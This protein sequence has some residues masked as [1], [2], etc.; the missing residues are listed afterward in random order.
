MRRACYPFAALWQ[1]VVFGAIIS[2][3]WTGAVA[4]GGASPRVAALHPPSAVADPQ[5][6]ALASGRHEAAPGIGS[7]SFNPLP[8]TASRMMRGQVLVVMNQASTGLQL[9]GIGPANGV[10][11]VAID[12]RAA[13]RAL[14]GSDGKWRLSLLPGLSVGPHV[15]TVDTLEVRADA[16]VTAG[17]REQVR[18]WVPDGAVGNFMARF[19]PAG[20][21]RRG[22]PGRLTQVAARAIEGGSIP[23][24]PGAGSIAGWPAIQTGSTVRYAQAEGPARD[25][26]PESRNVQSDGEGL[27]GAV[28][29]WLGES[30]KVYQE[31]VVPR[32]SEGGLRMGASA[33]PSSGEDWKGWGSVGFLSAEWIRGWVARSRQIYGAEVVARLSG[34]KAL[35]GVFGAWVRSGTDGAGMDV[36]RAG[37]SVDGREA[38]RLAADERARAEAERLAA[39]AARRRAEAEAARIA[40]RERAAARAEAEERLAAEREREAGERLRL[41]EAA[42]V[43]EMAEESRRNAD[44]AFAE[45]ERR[46]REQQER[47]AIEAEARRLAEERARTAREEARRARTERD[48]AERRRLANEE[49]VAAERERLAQEASGRARAEEERQQKAREIA[50]LERARADLERAGR[51]GAKRKDAERQREDA[52]RQRAERERVARELSERARAD[53]ERADRERAEQEA[54]E[55]AHLALRK[56]MEDRR[57]QAVLEGRGDSTPPAVRERSTDRSGS[58]NGAV[59]PRL[60]DIPVRLERPVRPD[61]PVRRVV[62]DRGTGAGAR[63]GDDRVP[64]LPTRGADLMSG[65]VARVVQP[66]PVRRP[67]E[68]WRVVPLRV[69]HEGSR[70]QARLSKSREADGR[71]QRRSGR[72]QAARAVAQC[73]SRAG[74]R[75]RPPGTYVVRLGDSLWRI[76]RRHYR[77]GRL[78]RRIHGANRRK[79]RNP[80]LIYPCQ[81]FHI[82]RKSKG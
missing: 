77:L 38:A 25:A 70:S 78:Y 1:G 52:E 6:D 27:F 24:R 69:F 57:R 12:G 5:Q 72:K 75:I 43:R 13:G 47:S 82:P 59:A 8:E 30:N 34:E 61:L 33:R 53:R 11:L 51:E 22:R 7:R 32:L 58:G 36:Q 56:E 4:S 2:V 49:R 65:Q 45:S 79:I 55:R 41:E 35:G 31:Q 37:S 29:R 28:L 23:A 62:R 46:R 39:E 50:A 20:R 16:Q 21:E 64:P 18:I 81:R 19:D 3:P 67:M 40:A 9:A 26:S 76:S 66:L 54:V 42:R 44:A 17:L 74:R 80:D 68:T 15:I 14:V 10:L 63:Q 60:P 73:H 48:A 71:R